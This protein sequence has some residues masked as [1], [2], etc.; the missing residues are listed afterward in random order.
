MPERFIANDL[1][2]KIWNICSQHERPP[3]FGGIVPISAVRTAQITAM[4]GGDI[5]DFEKALFIESEMLPW[6]RSEQEANSKRKEKPNAW[7]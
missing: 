4:Y 5:R 6:I 1:A 7:D 2:W 3:G